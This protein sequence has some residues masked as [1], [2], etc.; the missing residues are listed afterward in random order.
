VKDLVVEAFNSDAE[1]ETFGKRFG[2]ALVAAEK[3]AENASKAYK[4]SKT[5]KEDANS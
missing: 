4:A 3:A 2:L 1:A 5:P